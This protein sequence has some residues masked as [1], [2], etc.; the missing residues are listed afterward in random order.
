M[1][2]KLIT[3][4]T[5][6][7]SKKMADE[8]SVDVLPLMFT[9]DG[10]EY[11]DNF[12]ADMDPHIFYEKVRA[13]L[14]P[15]TTLI[16]TDR[17]LV[18][19][20]SYLERGIDIVYIAF[21]SVLSGTYQCAMQAAQQLR[22]EF[23]E[24]SLYVVDSMCA[25]MGEGLFVWQ[26]AKLRDGGMG[27][28]EL[29]DWLEKNKLRVVHWFTVDDINHLRRGGRL[30]A[31]QALLGTLM[32]IKPVLHLDNE[33]RLVPMEKVLGRKKSLATIVERLAERYD[34]SV[35]TVFVSHG[36]VPEEARAVEAMIKEKLPGVE[37]YTHTV[38]PVVGAHSGPGTMAVFCFGKSR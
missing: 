33:G 23:P 34:G 12:G 38:G 31:A 9:I 18:H 13:G 16:N 19:F 3:D 27:A 10:E 6:D 29:A 36:D 22:E 26:A 35:K 14:M 21:S 8:L 25:S 7:M 30:S 37:V 4:S 2:Y 17:F 11:K 5:M 28:A 24:R 1:S 20:R 32:Q 15:T